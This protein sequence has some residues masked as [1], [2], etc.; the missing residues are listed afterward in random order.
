MTPTIP[1]PLVRMLAW[2]DSCLSLAV[3][4]PA[5]LLLGSRCGFY[6][7]GAPDRGATVGEGVP[8]EGGRVGET[9][10][11]GRLDTGEGWL[12]GGG[13]EEAKEG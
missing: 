1:S 7:I 2:D 6:H 8:G 12:V 5:L 3:S 13:E 11:D 4:P 10:L 9:E